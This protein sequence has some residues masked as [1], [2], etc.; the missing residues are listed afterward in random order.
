MMP[1]LEKVAEVK[2]ALPITPA[3][4]FS[5][6]AQEVPGMYFFLGAA[7]EDPKDIYPNHS[8]KFQVNEK[9]LPIGVTA[10]TTVALDFLNSQ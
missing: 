7:P 2:E 6:Y 10:M 1:S 3:E 4:D 8:P 5:F 9:A